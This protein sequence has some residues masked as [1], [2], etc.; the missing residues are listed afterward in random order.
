MKKT[1]ILAIILSASTAV[2]AGNPDRIGQAGATQLNINGWGRGSGWGWASVSSVK[3]LESIYNNIGGLAH[4]DNTEIIFSRTSWLMGSDISI[5]TFG[6][7][8][9]IEIGRAH[10]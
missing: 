3:G 6:F 5:N 7:A 10:V 8:Q 2:L 4:T 9:N 1:I